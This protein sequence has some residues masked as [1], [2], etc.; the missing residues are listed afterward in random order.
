MFSQRLLQ[1]NTVKMQKRNVCL[2]YLTGFS[3]LSYFSVLCENKN[4]R[5]V[6]DGARTV[7]EV[8]I[9]DWFFFGGVGGCWI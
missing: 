1:Y 9:F 5:A 4:N 6:K 2:C 7:P 8:R 3:V